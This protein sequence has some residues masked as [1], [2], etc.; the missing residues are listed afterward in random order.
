MWVYSRINNAYSINVSPYATADT[1]KQGVNFEPL[2]SLNKRQKLRMTMTA[3]FATL[4]KKKNLLVSDRLAI[5]SNLTHYPYRINTLHAITQDLSFSACVI[6]MALYNG[7]LSP[8]FCRM[9]GHPG[10]PAGQPHTCPIH[11]HPGGNA[12]TPAVEAGMRHLASWLPCTKCPA[13]NLFTVFAMSTNTFSKGSLEAGSRCLILDGKAVIKGL[14]W[15][16]RPFHGFKPLQEDVLAL[17]LRKRGNEDDTAGHIIL[18]MLVRRL[19]MLGRRDLLELI[20]TVVMQRQFEG[21][22]EIFH[23]L[24]ELEAWFHGERSWP[25][26][27]TEKLPPENV[28]SS[29]TLAQN[30]AVAVNPE[31]T[32]PQER[33][34][35]RKKELKDLLPKL[36]LLHD[37]MTWVC[38]IIANGLPLAIGQCKVGKE[39]LVSIFTSDPGK[40]PMVFTPLSELDYEFGQCVENFPMHMAAKDSLWNVKVLPE[41]ASNAEMA[42]AARKLKTVDDELHLSDQML[43]IVRPK[44]SSAILGVWSPRLSRAGLLNRDSETNLWEVIP[45]GRGK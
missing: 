1:S 17:L 26:C 45:F 34:T 11:G 8:L 9:H 36:V 42:M 13:A 28:P 23:I 6:A 21:P 32:I 22:S 3:A 5:L 38:R 24:N 25:S 16:I 29:G 20:M 37:M 39:A 10:H 33:V 43:E 41:K 4:E 35:P 27:T 12:H 18:Q 15:E 2:D 30:N 31:M 44:D 40:Y 14:L 7:D 19:F